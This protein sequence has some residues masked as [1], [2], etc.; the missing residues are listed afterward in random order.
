MNKTSGI[1]G[2]INYLECDNI[3]TEGD[4]TKLHS[5]LIKF[6]KHRHL[7]IALSSTGFRYTMIDYSETDMLITDI[8]N[9]CDTEGLLEMLTKYEDE[10]IEQVILRGEK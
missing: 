10:K 5:C 2:I 7:G 1:M 8:G 9:N 4:N 3:K 6:P